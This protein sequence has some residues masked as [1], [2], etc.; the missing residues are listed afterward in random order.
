M[1]KED[2]YADFAGWSPDSDREPTER[3]DSPGPNP[4]TLAIQAWGDDFNDPFN[5]SAVAAKE[6]GLIDSGGKVTDKGREHLLSLF[7]KRTAALRE[8]A[9]VILNEKR[10]AAGDKK[11]S[12]GGEILTKI[13][14]LGLKKMAR[15]TTDGFSKDGKQIYLLTFQK[16]RK[17]DPIK[18]RGTVAELLAKLSEES[19]VYTLKQELAPQNQ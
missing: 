7:N 15:L 2:H 14:S 8:P 5:A 3:S 6:D 12:P 11:E 10:K 4:D 19:I 17:S 1:E 16:T 9:G 13:E 18:F